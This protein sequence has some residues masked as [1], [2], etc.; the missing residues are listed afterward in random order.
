MPAPMRKPAYTSTGWLRY[1]VIWVRPQTPAAMAKE[2]TRLGFSSLVVSEMTELKYICS[3]QGRWG[4]QGLWSPRG[5]P[6]CQE[7]R[8]GL[9][10]T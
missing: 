7:G 3:G 5:Q 2:N 1:C 4:G 8:P 10:D 6:G 9:T